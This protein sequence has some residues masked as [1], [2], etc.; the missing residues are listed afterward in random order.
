MR[1]AVGHHQRHHAGLFRITGSA[2]HE[3]VFEWRE[4]DDDNDDSASHA[5]RDHSQPSHG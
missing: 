5:G 2:P 4:D 1:D 3:L